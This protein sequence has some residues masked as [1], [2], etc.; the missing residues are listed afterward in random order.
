MMLLSFSLAVIAAPVFE[1]F[2]FRGLFQGWL[3]RCEDEA[4]D[5]NT[6]VAYLPH[7]W[8][9]ILVSGNLFWPRSP[10]PRRCSYPAHSIRHRARLSLSTTHRLAPSIAA[11]MFFNG[12]TMLLLWLQLSST[13]AG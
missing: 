5:S 9:P 6:Y 7:G 13:S 11:H 12:Y 8:F 3:E 10:W 4:L 1:E 2:A